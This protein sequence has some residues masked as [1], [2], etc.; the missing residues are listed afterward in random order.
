MAN[1]AYWQCEKPVSWDLRRGTFLLSLWQTEEAGWGLTVINFSH[2]GGEKHPLTVR[3]QAGPHGSPAAG[4]WLWL[5]KSQFWPKMGTFCFC[6]CVRRI[7]LMSCNVGLVW[8]GILLNDTNSSFSNSTPVSTVDVNR[9]SYKMRTYVHRVPPPPPTYVSYETTLG[10][11]RHPSLPHPHTM[12]PFMH[13]PPASMG[14]AL[15]VCRVWLQHH[16]TW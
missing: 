8:S 6:V 1:L 3:L 4:W 2:S 7:E 13:C 16:C 14:R 9:W 11:R 10:T 5:Q 12:T 15:S